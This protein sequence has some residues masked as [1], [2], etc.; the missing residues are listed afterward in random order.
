[1]VVED[2]EHTPGGTPLPGP[3]R[4]GPTATDREISCPPARN[5]MSAH[6]E[7]GMSAC[8]CQVHGTTWVASHGTTRRVMTG[9]P[10]G[11]QRSQPY[12]AISALL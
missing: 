4:P 3:T 10:T 6:K 11:A 9:V 1:M 12:G 8:I 2:L 7:I 5:Y